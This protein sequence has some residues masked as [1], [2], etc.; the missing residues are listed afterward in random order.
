METKLKDV[1]GGE[2]RYVTGNPTFV[3]EVKV[4]NYQLEPVNE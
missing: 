3:E 4:G 2:N 1:S